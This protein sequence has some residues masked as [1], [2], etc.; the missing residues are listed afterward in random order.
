MT[1]SFSKVGASTE[2]GA[3]QKLSELIQGDEAVIV[4]VVAR[5]PKQVPALQQ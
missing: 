4:E 3:L 2:P 1:P 5:L